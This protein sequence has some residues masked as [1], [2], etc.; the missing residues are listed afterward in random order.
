MKSS[1]GWV[2]KNKADAGKLFYENLFKAAPSV[3]PL[4]DND[5]SNQAAKLVSTVTFVVQHLNNFSL[6]KEQIRELGRKHKGYGAKPE[7]YPIVAEQLII[8]I[9]QGMGD[10]FTPETE[11]AWKKA[12]T[13]IAKNMIEAAEK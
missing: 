6:I 9:K 4:F 1:W 8:T 12:L 13:S 7:H 11:A 2:L 10:R 3:R 5:I